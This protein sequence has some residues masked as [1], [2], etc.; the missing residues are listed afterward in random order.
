MTLVRGFLDIPILKG[1]ITDTHF[2]KRNRMGRLLVFLARLN[3]PD[4]AAA[5]TLT[6][7]VRGIGVEEGAAVLLQPDGMA[8][9]VGHGSAYFVDPVVAEP[10]LSARTPLSSRDIGVQKVGPGHRFRVKSWTGDGLRYS[11]L[12]SN[13]QIHSTQPG[14]SVY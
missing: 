8:T 10:A 13:G 11:L 1:I 3:Q 9:V 7:T 5:G 6:A 12:V 14:G 2:A 4:S